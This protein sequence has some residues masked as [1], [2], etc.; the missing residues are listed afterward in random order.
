MKFNKNI[1]LS[2]VRYIQAISDTPFI[3]Y[4]N[5][6]NGVSIRFA[7]FLN[8]GIRF[9]SIYCSRGW[10]ND[11][12][13][14]TLF[15]PPPQSSNV[16]IYIFGHAWACVVCFFISKPLPLPQ[17]CIFLLCSAGKSTRK[18]NGR[19]IFYTLIGFPSSVTPQLQT[20]K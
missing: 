1:L 16:Y 19:S 7:K 8:Q 13:V 15:Y 4:I 9:F 17:L 3:F 6:S 18:S 14:L 2:L 10:K 5:K 12:T 20:I 11:Y